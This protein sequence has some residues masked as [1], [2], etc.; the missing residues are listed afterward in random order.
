MLNIIGLL[1]DRVINVELIGFVDLMVH[2]CNS[3]I[4]CAKLMVEGLVVFLSKTINSLTVIG[5]YAASALRR[6]V[7]GAWSQLSHH[8]DFLAGIR[9]SSVSC[10]I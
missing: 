2:W 7:K 5:Y 9:N 4:S 8:L 3:L 10:A 1:L 6:N